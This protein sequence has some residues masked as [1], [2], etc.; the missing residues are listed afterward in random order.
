MKISIVFLVLALGLIGSALY[1]ATDTR[2]NIAPA[3]PKENHRSKKGESGDFRGA[4]KVDNTSTGDATSDEDIARQ[5]KD[6]ERELSG[7]GAAAEEFSIEKAMSNQEF[8]LTPLQKQVRDTPAIARI[9]DVQAKE[10][11]VVL[12][13]GLDQNL[14]EGM[15]LAVRREYYIVAKLIVGATVDTSE[16]VANIA[17]HT[18]PTGIELRP[19]DAVIPWAD[20]VTLRK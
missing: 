12:D 3:P 10:G 1:I 4:E 7:E 19:G 17:P 6:L 15:D 20:I 9:K 13:S 5:L 11:F 8:A 14:R 2:A 18:I 16:S